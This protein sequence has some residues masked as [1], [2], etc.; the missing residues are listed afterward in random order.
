MKVLYLKN[1]A[2]DY[3]I[4]QIFDGFGDIGANVDGY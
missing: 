4:N 3:A 2:T 1:F